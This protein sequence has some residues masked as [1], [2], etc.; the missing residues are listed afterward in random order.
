MCCIYRVLCWCPMNCYGLTKVLVNELCRSANTLSTT[1]YWP[2]IGPEWSPDLNTGLWLVQ[3]THNSEEWTSLQTMDTAPDQNR[4]QSV[5]WFINTIDEV[6]TLA[7]GL[8]QRINVLI[9][10]LPGYSGLLQTHIQGIL[11]NIKRLH[12]FSVSV[13]IIFRKTF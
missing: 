10:E 1:Q 5:D 8:T 12:V 6:C 2:L 4:Y 13:G 9:L 3:L 7:G 11:S